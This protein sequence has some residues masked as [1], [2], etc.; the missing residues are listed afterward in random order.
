MK[1]RLPV[2]VVVVEWTM[3]HVEEPLLESTVVY[4]ASQRHVKLEGEAGSAGTHAPW[5][6]HGPLSVMLQNAW[7]AAVLRWVALDEHLLFGVS[8]LVDLS[9]ADLAAGSKEHPIS[10]EEV[11]SQVDEGIVIRPYVH[12][13]AIDAPI[14]AVAAHITAEAQGGRGGR[15]MILSV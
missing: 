6:S 3:A 9:G 14:Q 5:P 7:Q 13:V 15:K 10:E 11:V 8:G 1:Q 4:P 2:L 12:E